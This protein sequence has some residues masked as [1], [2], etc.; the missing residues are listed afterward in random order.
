MT[1]LLKDMPKSDLPRERLIAY[2]VENLSNQELISIILRTGTKGS[3]VKEV[4]SNILK[5]CK[6]VSALKDM[7]IN[8][9]KEIKGLG[10]VKAITL[11][12]ALELGRRVYE[13]KESVSNEKIKNSREAYKFFSKYIAREKQENL[14]A[15]YLDNQNRYI[16]HKLLFKGTLNSSIVHPREVF[17]HALLENASGIIVM[18]NH[19][20]GS[21]RPSASDDE[22]TRVLA[23]TGSIMGIKLLDHL[24]VSKN[25]YYSYVEEGRLQYE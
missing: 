7:T 3:S 12:A 17:K 24:V 10:E 25:G 20:S 1:V 9:L 21:T 5:E 8:R 16:S 11:T 18:H 23:Q 13:D 19:P 4:S 15:I 6:D 14:L 22:T 2:G